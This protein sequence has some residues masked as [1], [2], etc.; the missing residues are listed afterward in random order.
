MN[1]SVA[2]KSCHKNHARRQ[3]QLE[4]WL[5]ELPTDFFFILGEPRLVIPD[6]LS[7]NVSDRFED[8]APKILCACMSMLDHNTE[9][10]FFCDDDTYVRPDRLLGSGY[11]KLDYCG[12]VRTHGDV[13]TGGL[14]Y[15]QGSAFWLSARS[16]EHIV[17]AGEK[18]MRP[19]IIDDG[20]VGVALDG[21]VALTHDRRYWPGPDAWQCAPHPDNNI[22]TSHKCDPE[23]MR[24]MHK[25]FA[26]KS[27]QV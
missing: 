8:I 7:C 6:T 10:G 15:I 18:V 22:I 27:G 25:P 14:P 9:F 5:P 13:S 1:I 19:G 2:I 4:T 3:A 20:A 16:M 12:W 17:R 24:R 11:R 23:T 21:K 26:R